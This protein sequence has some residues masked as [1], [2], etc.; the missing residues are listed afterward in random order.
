MNESLS[1]RKTKKHHPFFLGVKLLPQM[2]TNVTQEN[3]HRQ[4][5]ISTGMQTL[6]F[7]VERAKVVLNAVVG[8]FRAS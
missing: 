4:Q 5:T 8:G 7:Q 6:A 3:H 2:Y 1:F